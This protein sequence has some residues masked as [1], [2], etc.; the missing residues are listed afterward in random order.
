MFTIIV[1]AENTTTYNSP[2]LLPWL[3]SPPHPPSPLIILSSVCFT[4]FE[5]DFQR[6]AG[7]DYKETRF[8]IPVEMFY[9]RFISKIA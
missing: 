9:P 3:A 8:N 6:R 7:A 2:D 5:A 1:S 4:H